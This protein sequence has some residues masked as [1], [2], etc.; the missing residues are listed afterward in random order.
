MDLQH[1]LH[2]LHWLQL[3]PLT[4]PVQRTR[5][6]DGGQRESLLLCITQ[7]CHVREARATLWVM[8]RFQVC[9]K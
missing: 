9:K 1:S 6:R 4:H 3:E 5:H 8:V 7:Q 2:W